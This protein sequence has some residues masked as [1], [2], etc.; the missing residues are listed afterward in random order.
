MSLAYFHTP[1]ALNDNSFF[2]CLDVVHIE[3]AQ[4]H[5][6]YQLIG[7]SRY[8]KQGSIPY[9]SFLKF[10]ARR[11][12]DSGILLLMN[13]LFLLSDFTPHHGYP[14][15]ECECLKSKYSEQQ[16]LDP[17]HGKASQECQHEAIGR[18][19]GRID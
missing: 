11:Q 19:M 3:H 10:L 14:S 6:L 4:K 7:A 8:G 1:C 9:L 5:R 12:N 16:L 15:Q 13:L 18:M 2:A 17:R